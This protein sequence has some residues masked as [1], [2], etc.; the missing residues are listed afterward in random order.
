[1]T[2]IKF[3]VNVYSKYLNLYLLENSHLRDVLK[4]ILTD[5]QLG[6]ILVQKFGLNALAQ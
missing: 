5:Y 1:M 3:F 6:I 2:K 4:F